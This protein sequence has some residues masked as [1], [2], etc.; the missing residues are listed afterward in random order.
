MVPRLPSR[1]LGRGGCGMPGVGLQ[2]GEDGVAD[3]PFQAA[4]GFFAGLAF[5]PFLV[6]VGA[7]GAVLVADLGDRGHVDRVVEAA[8]A[9]P[10]QPVD[11]P[12]ARR[13]LDGGGAVVGGE[14]IPAGEAG[15][16]PDIA[17]DR[18]GD[19]RADPE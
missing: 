18:S 11:F 6:V 8:V 16:V 17:D 3:L 2:A 12:A 4:Q 19:D 15:H 14:L 5:G 1:A 7:A 13:Y 9:A 10:G